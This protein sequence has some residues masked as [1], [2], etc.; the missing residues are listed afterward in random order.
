MEDCFGAAKNECGLDQYEVRRYTS[1][2]RHITL[3]M[4]AFAFLTVLAA[5]A[6]QK[7]ERPIQPMSSPSPWQR[8]DDSWQLSFPERPDNIPSITS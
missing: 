6:Q 2:Y 8:F 1:W 4:L 3:S 5:Q 7:G